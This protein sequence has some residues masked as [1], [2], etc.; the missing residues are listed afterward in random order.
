MIDWPSAGR[1]I[2]MFVPS[3]TVN[4]TMAGVRAAVAVVICSGAMPNTNATPTRTA[5]PAIIPES[6]RAPLAEV[7][8]LMMCPPERQVPK[9]LG[10]A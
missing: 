1:L 5:P 9:G 10:L 3:L 4:R 6:G 2:E 8:D 7:S